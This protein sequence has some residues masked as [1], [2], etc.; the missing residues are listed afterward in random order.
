MILSL[1][2]SSFI[3]FFALP[4]QLIERPLSL[5]GMVGTILFLLAFCIG[6]WVVKRPTV[7]FFPVVIEPLNFRSADIVLKIA[8]LISIFALSI[9]FLQGELSN[10]TSAYESRSDRANALKLGKDSVSTIWF[11]IGFLTYPAGFVFLFRQ[12]IFEPG[13]RITQIMFFGVLPI[14]IAALVMGGRS[15]L[16]YAIIGVIFSLYARRKMFKG[17]LK[18]HAGKYERYLKFFYAVALVLAIALAV[19]YFAAVFTQR[20]QDVGGASGMLDVAEDR[21][22]VSFRGKNSAFLIEL[23]G[24]QL[25]YQFSVFIW[26]LFQGPF[27]GSFLITD[28][29]GSMQM[30]TY[31]IDLVTA[32]M[33]RLNPDLLSSNFELLSELGVYGFFPSAFGSLYVDFSYFGLL[34]ASVWGAFAGYVY[35]KVQRNLDRRWYL[36]APFVSMGIFFSLLNTPLGFTNGLVTHIW[37]LITFILL[38]RTRTQLVRV[39]S[40]R[41]GS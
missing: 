32:L 23:F 7:R 31:G 24:I 10:L 13:F 14:L 38:R 37:L 6:V 19:Y 8:V 29:Q 35:Q 2:V 34:L 30:G 40:I 15:P 25:Y 41:R 1:W 36:I 39:A 28:Y 26:Y 33:R 3:L 17:A 18:T 11:K 16:L 4:F 12:I 9:D 5:G 20:A 27:I 21:W 22:G